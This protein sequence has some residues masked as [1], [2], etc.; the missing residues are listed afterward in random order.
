[1]NCRSLA[2]TY[3]I[4]IANLP[5]WTSTGSVDKSDLTLRREPARALQLIGLSEAIHIRRAIN[6]RVI[7]LRPCPF[8][9][10]VDAV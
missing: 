7:H 8:L 1:M 9:P 2:S 10:H 4:K 3:R 5:M 6:F